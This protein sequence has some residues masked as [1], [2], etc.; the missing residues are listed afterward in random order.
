MTQAQVS[1]VVNTTRTVAQ[2]GLSSGY[3]TL[4]CS[5]P[6]ASLDDDCSEEPSFPVDVAVTV[7]EGYCVQRCVG[8]Q[9][10]AEVSGGTR[11]CLPHSSTLKMEAKIA[12]G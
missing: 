7:S 4:Q 12:G 10:F 6:S 3:V 2:D 5:S 1:L 8:F 9:A 11:P